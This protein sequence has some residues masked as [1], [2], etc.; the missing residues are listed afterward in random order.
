MKKIVIGII[1]LIM[2][3]NVFSQADA[4]IEAMKKNIKDLDSNK[5][6]QEWIVLSNSFER[7]AQMET[8]KWLPDYYVAYCNLMAGVM[9]KK[10]RKKDDFLDKAMTSIEKA[11][12]LCEAENAEILGLKSFIYQIQISV[13]P[14]KRG[15]SYGEKSD[16]CLTRAMELAPD[17][18]R[19]YLLKGDNLFYTPP[20][21]GGDKAKACEMYQTAQE[22]FETFEPE[23]EISP[24]WGMAYLQHQLKNCEEKK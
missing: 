7:I 5:T 20:M 24:D 8:D 16:A 4:Y 14:M 23:S 11:E 12:K 2:A 3:N 18:P 13:A 15:K 17:N 1:V 6:Q 21:F 10:K 19:M 22:K 9:E